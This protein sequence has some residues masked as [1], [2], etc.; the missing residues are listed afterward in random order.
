MGIYLRPKSVRHFKRTTE[1]V[2]AVLVCPPPQKA[3]TG[4]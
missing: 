2:E 4:R 3:K 1:S